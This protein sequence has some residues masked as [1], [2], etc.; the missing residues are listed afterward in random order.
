MAYGFLHKD[1]FE[2]ETNILVYDLG[3]GTFDVSVLTVNVAQF[4]VKATSGDTH[5]GGEDFDNR[6]VDHFV[7]LIN[8]KYKKDIKDNK[9]ALG[10]LRTHSERIKRTLSSA[11]N[12][13]VYD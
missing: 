2:T 11:T 6:M 10:R 4:N 12:T 7:A 3:G 13:I 5:L 9:R 8:R 1:N